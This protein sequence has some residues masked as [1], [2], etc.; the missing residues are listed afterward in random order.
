MFCSTRDWPNCKQLKSVLSKDRF[1]HTDSWW[2]LLAR[3]R[4]EKRRDPTGTVCSIQSNGTQRPSKAYPS[5]HIFHSD[6]LMSQI[7]S[8]RWTSVRFI[9]ISR[10]IGIPVGSPGSESVAVQVS[11]RLSQ[12]PSESI[13]IKL[14]PFRACHRRSRDPPAA[15]PGRGSCARHPCAHPARARHPACAVCPPPPH[16]RRSASPDQG[17]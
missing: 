3:L 13:T 14:L 15:P 17:G 9:L 16:C 10:L 1:R 4:W 8:S 12:S 6:S 7:L 11:R 5:R 2:Q